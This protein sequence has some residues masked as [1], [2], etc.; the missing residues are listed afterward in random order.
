MRDERGP[1]MQ[2]RRI[3]F[4]KAWISE[5]VPEFDNIATYALRPAG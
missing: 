1:S 4:V 2:V 3:D 5:E